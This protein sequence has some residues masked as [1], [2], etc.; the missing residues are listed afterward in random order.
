MEVVLNKDVKK[1]GFR[2]DVVRVRDGYFRN[3]LWPRGMADVATERRKALAETFK[4]KRVMEKEQLAANAK[5]VLARLK[6][7]TVTVKAKVSAKGKL[8]AGVTEADVIEAVEAASKIKLEKENLKMEHFKALGEHEAVVH[9]G[10]NM[11]QKITVVV[12]KA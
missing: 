5:E 10:P 6:D 9:L 7:L 8:Y 11:E 4:Q 3:F 1:L 12:E 2:G